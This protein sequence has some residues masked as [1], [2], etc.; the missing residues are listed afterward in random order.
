MTEKV[1]SVIGLDYEKM[2]VATIIQ[3]GELDS[4]VTE[5][6]PRKLK[7]MINDMIGIG[8]L[9]MAFDNARDVTDRFR[10]KLRSECLNYDDTTLEDLEEKLSQDE[11][12]KG[13]SE[14]ELAQVSKKLGELE[15]KELS[16]Q[17]S[18]RH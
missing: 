7:E 3:Q 4:I 15:S 11:Q 9:H 6:S 1:A 10:A 2:K 8:S 13:G 5:Y 14:N 12:E 17:A 16:F 18:L